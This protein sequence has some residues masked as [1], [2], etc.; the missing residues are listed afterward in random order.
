MSQENVRVMRAAFDAW[1]AQDMNSFHELLDASVVL[2]APN[3]WPEPGPFNGRESV[4]SEYRRL[5]DAF[6]AD[7]LEPIGDF[8]DAG[9]YVAVRYI[10]H[11]AGHGPAAALELTVVLTVRNGRIVEIRHFW[12]HAEALEAVGLRE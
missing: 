1:N 9:D 8:I 6:D 2:R 3:D 5:R 4:M 11:G 12:G 7:A 10:W